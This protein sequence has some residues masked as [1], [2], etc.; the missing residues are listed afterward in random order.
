MKEKQN[1]ILPIM[2][3]TAGHVDH[4]KTSLVKL[5]T[6]CDTDRLKE[7]KERGL[8]I[9]LGFAPC[10]LPGSRV[11]GIIDVPGH[12]DFIRNMVAGA[13]SMDILM[14]IIAADDSIMPQT[15]EHLQIIEQLRTP[16]I[17]VVITKIDLIDKELLDLVMEDVEE[18]IANT[19][20]KNVPICPMSNITLDGISNVRK[21][22]DKLVSKVERSND[23]RLFRMNIERTFSVKGHGTIA[24]GIPISGSLSIGDKVT[25][26]PSGITS[27]VRAIQ[28]YKSQVED[29][30][31][32][33]CAAINLP[34]ISID[35][36]E[37]GMT[38]ISEFS[39]Y[40][41][42]KFI[43]AEVQNKK[44]TYKIPNNISVRFHFGTGSSMAKITFL[45]GE[46]LE[47]GNKSFAKI[48]LST[49]ITITTG[50][51]FIIR[52]LSPSITLGGGVV[53]T[54]SSKKIN[55]D[56]SNYSKAIKSITAG[57]FFEAELL[58]TTK[59]IYTYNELIKLTNMSNSD[60]E[61]HLKKAINNTT[62]SDNTAFMGLTDLG[63]HAYLANNQLPLALSNLTKLL[64]RYHDVKPTS[65][66]IDSAYFA[67]EYNISKK[68]FAIFAKVISSNSSDIT[69]SYK[70]LS[71]TSFKPTITRDEILKINKMIEIV[72][73]QGI[74]APA[75]G[76]LI[77]ELKSNKKEMN[78]LI[79][80]LTEE[81]KIV[82]VG[83]NIIDKQ[84]FE[85]IKIKLEN[86]FENKTILEINDFRGLTNASRN[87]SVALLEKFD[88]LGIT[89]RTENGREK[90]YVT[91]D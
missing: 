32:N 3:G 61:L 38:L 69:F 53:L 41:A 54:T 51:K 37:R 4:G 76:D 24:T 67:K 40:T 20:Y 68:N 84:T 34:D 44:S 16:Q 13:A 29:S 56:Y 2:I 33:I 43:V 50:D 8:T 82:T 17:M 65:W 63:D 73:T 27:R 49:P 18:F 85:S 66:G 87:F 39:N 52:Q 10:K 42:S 58:S 47:V 81:D 7:E 30:E 64:T 12:L 62:K 83:K 22:L 55:K 79:K 45:S 80:I 48:R 15:K 75:I 77:T 89:K 9:D 72:T 78:K 70:R 46:N 25:L 23:A 5:L 1:K 86:F 28:N 59:A 71:L 57:D 91:L 90:K 88:N 6:G 60:A 74:I 14:L 19:P 21:E 26:Q 11:V 36:I 35:Q 31:A